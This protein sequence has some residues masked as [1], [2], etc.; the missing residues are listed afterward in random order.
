MTKKEARAL[1]SEK[2]MSLSAAERNR[3][4]DLILI[5]FQ[6]LDVEI[7]SL[8]M[9]Y[10]PLESRH[11]FNTQLITDYCYFKNPGQL[12][13]YPVVDA[14][15]QTMH[16]VAV[17]D[18]TFFKKNKY[19]IDEPVEGME[20]FAEEIDMVLVPLLAFD[21]RGYRV[22]YGKGY[23]DKFLKE[24]RDDV[25]K[26]GFSYFPPLDRIADANR[27]DVRLDYC[28]TPGDTYRF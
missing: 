24:C 21:K 3:M 27:H 16:A 17:N 6:H 10:A 12:L 8:I 22:G 18:D 1:Y 25:V 7:P 9:T 11:E 20:L 5:Q 15:E 26:V 4:D 14:G 19:G 28:I 23:Y 2:R 13:F